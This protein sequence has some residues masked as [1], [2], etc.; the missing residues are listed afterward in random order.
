MLNEFNS[1]ATTMCQMLGHM[2]K[3]KNTDIWPLKRR[4]IFNAKYW[5][6]IY[7]KT[8]FSEV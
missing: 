1:F 5:T 8:D 7:V 4:F 2:A 6:K 3:I